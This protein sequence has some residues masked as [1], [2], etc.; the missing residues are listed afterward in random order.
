MSGV[1]GKSI[2]KINEGAGADLAFM[3]VLVA[4]LAIREGIRS[5]KKKRADMKLQA[6]QELE[7]KEMSDKFEAMR[8]AHESDPEYPPQHRPHD[9]GLYPAGSHGDVDGPGSV[10]DPHA[11]HGDHLLLLPV[12]PEAV[13]QVH[14]PARGRAP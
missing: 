4:F 6:K 14:T 3:G 9:S 5:F 7:R 10:R 12:L 13:L 2:E 1:Y 11:D 8:K